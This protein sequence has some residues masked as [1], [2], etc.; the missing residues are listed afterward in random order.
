MN[1]KKAL[2]P[3]FM[4]LLNSTLIAGII[5]FIFT[6]FSKC[7]GGMMPPCNPGEKVYPPLLGCTNYCATPFNHALTLIFEIAVIFVPLFLIIYIL[8]TIIFDRNK[9]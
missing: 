6:I 2:K 7:M 3:Y 1:F 9:T 5:T 4:K 8:L